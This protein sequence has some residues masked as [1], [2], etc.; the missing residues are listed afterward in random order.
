MGDPRGGGGGI[1]Q[2]GVSDDMEA[3]GGGGVSWKVEQRILQEEEVRT[4][5]RKEAHG[6]VGHRA[7]DLQ[8]PPAGTRVVPQIFSDVRPRDVGP[9]ERVRGH[10]GS[11]AKGNGGDQG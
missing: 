10:S 6:H 1:D 7:P 8:L 3:A 11:D 4:P 5:P 2:T 9:E